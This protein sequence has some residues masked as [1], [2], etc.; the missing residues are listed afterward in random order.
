MTKLLALEKMHQ[1][2]RV[3]DVAVAHCA[4]LAVVAARLISDGVQ[5]HSRQSTEQSS[6]LTLH[7]FFLVSY[8][9]HVTILECIEK[10]NDVCVINI[11]RNLP[12]TLF[13]MCTLMNE[14]SKYLLT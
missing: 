2:P 8:S 3:A 7:T 12:K 11:E 9:H 5:G 14:V 10:I 1:V 13:V 4:S 6:Y